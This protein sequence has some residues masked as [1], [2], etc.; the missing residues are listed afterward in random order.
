MMRSSGTCWWSNGLRACAHEIVPLHLGRAWL[1]IGFLTVPHHSAYPT[2]AENMS[3]S[4]FINSLYDTDLAVANTNRCHQD[5]QPAVTLGLHFQA[6]LSL[7]IHFKTVAALTVLH[8]KN[9]VYYILS[10]RYCLTLHGLTATSRWGLHLTD[11]GCPPKSTITG[12]MLPPTPGAVTG[13]PSSQ[14]V[15]DVGKGIIH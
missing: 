10:M 5:P 12:G 3:M 15:K 9:F 14:S 1:Q 4:V 2:Q 13:L 6:Y 11:K 8:F 7:Q